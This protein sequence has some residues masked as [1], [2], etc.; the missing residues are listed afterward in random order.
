[1]PAPGGGTRLLA[2]ATPAAGP[3]APDRLREALRE[4]LPDYLVPA[5]VIPVDHWPLTAN[6]KLD[7]NALPE[8]EAAATPGGRAPATP[9]EEIVAHL[10]AE[11]LGREQVGADDDF[12]ALGGHSLLATRLA[13]R[14][15]AALDVSLSVRDVFEAATVAALARRVQHA[16]RAPE[17]LRP[18][19]LSLI[20]ISER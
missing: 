11:I 17:P 8:P 7:R 13:S 18:R 5:A 6:G 19:P 14:I 15:R 12:F 20:H 1:R 10:F 2:Y 16:G 3:L 9:Q 4:R